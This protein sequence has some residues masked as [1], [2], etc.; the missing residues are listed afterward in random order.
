MLSTARTPKRTHTFSAPLPRPRS[1]RN[2]V[3]ASLRINTARVDE[4]RAACQPF[5]QQVPHS[6]QTA[7]T[8]PRPA[9]RP[10]FSRSSIHD[11]P[12]ERDE[13]HVPPCLGLH[14]DLQ[15]HDLPTS[16]LRVDLSE[17]SARSAMRHQQLQQLR[18]RVAATLD[19]AASATAPVA[20]PPCQPSP[21]SSRPASASLQR[22]LACDLSSPNPGPLRSSFGASSS[23][24]RACRSASEGS[25]AGHIASR[26][27]PQE[28]PEQVAGVPAQ[29]QRPHGSQVA[30]LAANASARRQADLARTAAAVVAAEQ[31]AHGS[32]SNRMFQRLRDTRSAFWGEGLWS[33]SEAALEV[34]PDNVQGPRDQEELFKGNTDEEGAQMAKNGVEMFS[35][36]ARKHE[37]DTCCICLQ[38]MTVGEWV[39]MLGCGHTLHHPCLL[40]LMWGQTS[41]V[42]PICRTVFSE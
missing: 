24:P 22:E 9:D 8:S 3:G 29:P 34:L 11:S 16:Q 36:S 39:R 25:S 20:A 7:D 6:A 37:E 15:G 18:G 42:C 4:A 13:G 1:S 10:S 31:Q 26:A 17:L 30:L 21:L 40:Q 35:C 5:S 41:C 23:R 28:G 27:R 2:K 14:I 32:S 19:L 33:P 12:I 38:A